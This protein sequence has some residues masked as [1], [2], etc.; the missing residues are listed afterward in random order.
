VRRI[1][2]ERYKD[3]QDAGDFSL[4]QHPPP[5]RRVGRPLAAPIVARQRRQSPIVEIVR[6][7]SQRA[8]GPFDPR[9]ATPG[10]GVVFDDALVGRAAAWSNGDG[11]IALDCHERDEPRRLRPTRAHD[12]YSDG[13]D[14]RLAQL[15]GRLEQ[16]RMRCR[17]CS[18]MTP[19]RPPTSC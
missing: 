4:H 8:D 9:A 15:A 19:E 6:D 3:E 16:M 14:P 12:V 1:N 5:R 13:R 17:K 2:Q 18:S 11:L 10:L 7:L